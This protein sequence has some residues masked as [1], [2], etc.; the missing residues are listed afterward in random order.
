M[1]YL[2]MVFVRWNVFEFISVNFK[3]MEIGFYLLCYLIKYL[4]VILKGCNVV[5]LNLLIIVEIR[6]VNMFIWLLKMNFL[7]IVNN[8][9]K[10][11]F[12]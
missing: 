7:C 8:N 6:C 1:Y 4:L 5:C 2:F 9:R 12:D 11:G 3:L 10:I